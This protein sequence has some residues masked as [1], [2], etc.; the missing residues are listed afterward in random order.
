MILT[1]VMEYARR[2]GVSKIVILGAGCGY[3]NN[4]QVPFRET[5]FWDGFPDMDCYGYSMSKKMSI[6]QSWAYRAQYGFNSVILLPANLYGPY[7]NFDLDTSHVVP[8]LIHKFVE[9][10][11]NN[12]PKVMVWGSGKATREFLYVDDVAQVI[13]DIVER[14][15]ESGPFN[16]GTGVETSINALANTIKEIVGYRGEIVWDHSKPDGQLRRC[17]DVN[18]LQQ[19][20][21]Y[22]PSTLLIDGLHKTIMW[23]Y[24]QV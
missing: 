5:Q 7:D 2:N 9:A 22:I 12:M 18:L 17:Y 11:I 3:P 1:L 4:L 19:K 8:A 14:V 24:N 15:D 16:L 23:Y 10:K 20:L 13:V 6:V 21:G